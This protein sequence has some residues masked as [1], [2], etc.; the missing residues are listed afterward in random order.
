MKDTEYYA[1]MRDTKKY[2]L[3]ANIFGA[4]SITIL[5][6][7]DW[8]TAIAVYIAIVAKISSFNLYNMIREL[9]KYEEEPNR[10]EPPPAP[11]KKE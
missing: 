11:P 3:I 4:L 5:A 9:K 2:L 10:P 1:L 7:H 8:I 6:L